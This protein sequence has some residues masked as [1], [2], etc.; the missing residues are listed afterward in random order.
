MFPQSCRTI[1]KAGLSLMH[2]CCSGS[3]EVRLGLESES[4]DGGEGSEEEGSREL[5]PA[6]LEA[7]GPKGV[8]S[9]LSLPAL[10]ISP[11]PL[12]HSPFLP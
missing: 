2:Q 9:L 10:R 1:P 4:R 12:A 3:H 5:N 7:L 11:Q 8:C 6:R